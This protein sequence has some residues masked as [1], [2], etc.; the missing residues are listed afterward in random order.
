MEER[1]MRIA[2]FGQA[3]FGKDV[4]DALLKAGE[5]VV[6]VSTP[7]GGARPDPLRV[8]A[9]EAG[10]PVIETPSLRR[11]GPLAEFAAWQPELLVF[12]FVTDI[13]RQPVL[14]LAK[15]GAIQYHPSLLPR[16]RGRSSMNWPIIAGETKTGLSI[17][18]VD[19]GVDT[20]PILLQ[21]EIEIGPDDTLGSIYFGRLYG[22]GVEALVDAVAMVREGRAP[23]IPQDEALATY[24]APIGP[25]H[26]RIDFTRPAQVVYN[27]I[28]GCDPAPGAS[29]VLR[30]TS[31]RLF[32]CALVEGHSNQP[33]GTVTTLVDGKASVAL[34]GGTLIVGRVQQD[35]PKVAAGDVLAVGDV[36]EGC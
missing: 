4:F 11:E 31:T 35:G 2:L 16:H 28:R 30:G 13:V 34:I 36:L 5:E 18:W 33:P 7:K 10:I 9:E 22:M 27:H 19:A 1:E 8:A 12:A 15:H 25:E 17:F 6:G 14:D 24:E 26:A 32:D 3:A 23:S 29:A 20:G 21:R